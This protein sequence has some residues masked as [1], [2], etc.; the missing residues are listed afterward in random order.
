MSILPG[1]Y[2]IS[3]SFAGA[4]STFGIL[5]ATKFCHWWEGEADHLPIPAELSLNCWTSCPIPWFQ[6]FSV[7]V[8]F[9]QS[10]LLPISLDGTVASSKDVERFLLHCFSRLVIQEFL[11]GLTEVIF[12][13]D[14][15]FHISNSRRYFWAS[16][17]V[18]TIWQ[19]AGGTGVTLVPVPAKTARSHSDIK[20]K[21][22]FDVPA[23]IYSFGFESWHGA[24]PRTPTWIYL[25]VIFHC[26]GRRLNREPCDKDFPGYWVCR[27]YQVCRVYIC[28]V[29]LPQSDCIM[30]YTLWHY[31]FDWVSDR[32]C[33]F[34]STFLLFEYY[35]KEIYFR[36]LFL[37][38]LHLRRSVP[39]GSLI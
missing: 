34:R 38:Q 39:N 8:R 5:H 15:A 24:K 32:D 14:D 7:P 19:M 35:F 11:S 1:V 36:S 13:T 33:P 4:C 3:F 37:I 9:S 2:P 30:T 12:C 27:V 20:G 28:P 23:V 31:L 10:E 18:C 29:R 16:V 26:H 22:S 21:R 25:F 17:C 6:F